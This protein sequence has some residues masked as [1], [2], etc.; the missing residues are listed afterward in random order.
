MALTGQTAVQRPHRV[1]LSLFQSICQSR[2]LTLKVEG[3]YDAQKFSDGLRDLRDRIVAPYP[4]F[5]VFFDRGIT[6]GFLSHT[7]YGT[8]D[9]TVPSMV[10]EL[11]PRFDAVVEGVAV[12]TWLDQAISG[13][14]WNSVSAF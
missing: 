6:H 13:G 2:S 11:P 5:R 3:M 9:I 10:Q 8:I 14:E 1:H 12:T 7:S 4:N